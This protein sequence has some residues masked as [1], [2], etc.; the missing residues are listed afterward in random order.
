MR[1]LAV[2]ATIMLAT[3]PSFA[4]PPKAAGWSGTWRNDANSVHIKTAPCGRGMCGTVVWASEKAK[5]DVAANGGTLIGSQLFKDFTLGDDG[6]WHGQV[7]IP[8]IG[9]SFT[10]TITLNDA[11][12]LTGSGCLFR[13]LACKTQVWKRVR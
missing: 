12:T 4:T 2:A 6:V 3:A 8:D 9:K 10:G 7:Y 5:A 11:N 13:G 1:I